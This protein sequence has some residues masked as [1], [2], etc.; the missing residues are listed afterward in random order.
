MQIDEYLATG[1]VSGIEEDEAKEEKNKTT[2]MALKF[3]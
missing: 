2:D 3:I 1:T